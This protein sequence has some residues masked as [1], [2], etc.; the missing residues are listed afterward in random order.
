MSSL[1]DYPSTVSSKILLVGDSGA[2]KTST[3]AS[4]VEAGFE[5]FVADCDNGLSVLMNHLPAD[6]LDRVRFLTFRDRGT[7]KPDA[8]QRRREMVSTKGWIE[9]QENYG[10]LDSWDS[11]RVFVLDSLT[12]AGKAAINFTLH[13]NN[14]NI[15]SQVSQAEWGDAARHIENMISHLTSDHIKCHVVVMTHL[16]Y[17]EDDASGLV[18]AFPTCVGARLPTIIPRYFNDMYLVKRGKDGK[19][20]LRSAPNGQ[21]MLKS[22]R[23]NLIEPE[24]EA[25]IGKLIK[26]LNSENK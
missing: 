16:R 17:I 10:K 24:G 5:V 19:I 1:K 3:I 8:G 2:G 11:N 18:S 4:M 14:K 12:F 15:E 25:D 21:I 7:G 13:L 22:S 20:K 9:G 23:P 6:K 26:L